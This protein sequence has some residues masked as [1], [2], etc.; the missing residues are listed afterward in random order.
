MNEERWHVTQYVNGEQIS[1]HVY[2]DWDYARFQIR[3]KG[4]LSGTNVLARSS[5]CECRGR[6]S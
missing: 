6:L 5:K 3:S 2:T 4:L 1:H